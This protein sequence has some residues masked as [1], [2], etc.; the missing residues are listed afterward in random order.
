MTLR[1]K[2][3]V[4]ATGMSGRPS[5]PRIPG[6]ETFEGDYHHSSK[7]PG[8]EPYRGKHCVI[9]GSNNSAHDIAA[10]LWENGAAS[11]T[12]VQR[13]STHIIRSDTFVDLVTGPLFSEEA[14]AKGITNDMADMIFASF[15]YK[16]CVVVFFVVG[17]LIC[18]VG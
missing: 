8:A 16:V 14:L 17:G 4:L 15:P 13:S 3:L 6:A 2:Q 18:G 7:H 10:D 1:P 5:M 12:M 11:V 9:L